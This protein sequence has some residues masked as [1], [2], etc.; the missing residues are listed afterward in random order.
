M[1][2]LVLPGLLAPNSDPVKKHLLTTDDLP[3]ESYPP[4]NY[5]IGSTQGILYNANGGSIDLTGC[6]FEN[7]TGAPVLYFCQIIFV[8]EDLNVVGTPES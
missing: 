2:S 4:Q 6:K 8:K 1:I 7:I 3:F 5:S